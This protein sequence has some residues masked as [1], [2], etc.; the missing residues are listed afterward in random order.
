MCVCVFFF[1]V[2]PLKEPLGKTE[3]R[4][5]FSR[6]SSPLNVTWLARDQSTG[7]KIGDNLP[8][9][10]Q[11]WEGLFLCKKSQEVCIVLCWIFAQIYIKT[12]TTLPGVVLTE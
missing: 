11:I 2:S 1:A 12:E 8:I 10:H 6:E 5:P 9:M 3:T 7:Y 4:A